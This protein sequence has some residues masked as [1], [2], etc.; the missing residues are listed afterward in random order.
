[1]KI[2]VKFK[3]KRGYPLEGDDGFYRE[4]LSGGGPNETNAFYRTGRADGMMVTHKFI[5]DAGFVYRNTDFGLS[6]Q[7]AY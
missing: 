4:D 5:P 7:D 6:T 2:A 3:L 1:M